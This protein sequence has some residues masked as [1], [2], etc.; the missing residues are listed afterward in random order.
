MTVRLEFKRFAVVA[1]FCTCGSIASESA[2]VI[3]RP[4]PEISA[5]YS[6]TSFK[7]V[8]YL[9]EAFIDTKPA[10]RNDAIPVGELG[11]NGGD[12]EAIVGLAQE[13]ADNKHDRF[14]SVLIAYKGRLLFESYYLRGRVNLPHYQAS[15]TKAYTG[16]AVGRAIQL[17]YL[18]MADLHK[19]LI[20]FLKGLDRTKFVEGAETITLHKAMTMQSGLRIS[21]D[22]MKE[23]RGNPAPL[24]GLGLVQTYLEQSEPIT[25]QSQSFYYQSADPALVM[26]VLEAIVP[27][28]AR[29]FIKDEVL[30]KMGIHNYQWRDDINGLPRGASGASMISRDMLKWG[31]MALDSGRWMGEQL[32]SN[33]FVNQATSKIVQPDVE[34]IVTPDESSGSYYGYYWWL[35]DLKVGNESYLVKS[36]QGGGGQYIIVVEELDLLVVATAHNKGFHHKTL[37]LMANRILPAFTQ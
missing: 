34:D 35:D 9:Q 12:K 19:P 33:A 3:A 7:D 26:Q 28:R 23:L 10:D 4:A 37:S 15:T 14:D 32:V 25:P 18:T 27:G 30:K 6:Q 2:V 11:I 13:I 8:P 5:D 20:S 29:D 16:L 21:H 24:K 31:M 1:L 36:A 17:G 22:K